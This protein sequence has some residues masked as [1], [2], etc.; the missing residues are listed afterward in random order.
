MSYLNSSS[1]SL[2]PDTESLIGLLLELE[3]CV[4]QTT[5]NLAERV[6]SREGILLTDDVQ[7]LFYRMAKAAY[8][9]SLDSVVSLLRD[10]SLNLTADQLLVACEKLSARQLGLAEKQ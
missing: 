5:Y 1:N 3:D 6:A 10:P 7:V 8:T 4:A 2:S 9:S